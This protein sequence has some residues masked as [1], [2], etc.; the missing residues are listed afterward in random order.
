MNLI[1]I[2]PHYETKEGYKKLKKCL[3]KHSWDTKEIEPD[4]KTR[5][6]RL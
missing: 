6:K 1:L 2:N 4:E 3:S 5:T